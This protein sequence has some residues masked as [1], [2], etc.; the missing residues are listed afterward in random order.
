MKS[1]ADLQSG[2]NDMQL[3]K[4]VTGTIL[5]I[6]L[7]AIPTMLFLQR[8]MAYCRVCSNGY[9]VVFGLCAC[10]EVHKLVEAGQTQIMIMCWRWRKK[11]LCNDI[12]MTRQIS[13][14]QGEM[15]VIFSSNGRHSL[16]CKCCELLMQG[17]EVHIIFLISIEAD[18]SRSNEE[19]EI[20]KI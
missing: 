13:P 8:N 19:H 17:F 9:E 5:T 20:M 18:A 4:K 12:M 7:F 15:F 16:S 11:S 2:V 3:H 1:L 10:A 14:S 6:D